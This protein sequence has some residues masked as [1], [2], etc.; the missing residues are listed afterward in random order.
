MVSDNHTP[1]LINKST[2]NKLNYDTVKNNLT[3][4][5]VNT[6]ALD[7]INGSNIMFI[8]SLT[9]NPQSKNLSKTNYFSLL[10]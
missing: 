1:S 2:Y 10:E 7:I 9:S 3:T 8:Y 5:K 6:P 4:L